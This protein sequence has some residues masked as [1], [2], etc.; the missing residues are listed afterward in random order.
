MSDQSA[1]RQIRTFTPKAP[2]HK[3]TGWLH[4]HLGDNR[5]GQLREARQIIAR[6]LRRPARAFGSELIKADTGPNWRFAII[7]AAAV[8]GKLPAPR[9]LPDAKS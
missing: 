8:R 2:V 7:K 9:E 6:R 4:P 1:S 3:D 5:G